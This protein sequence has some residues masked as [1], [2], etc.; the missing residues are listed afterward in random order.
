MRVEGKPELTKKL[1]ENF[2][3][4]LSDL[5]HVVNFAFNMKSHD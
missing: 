1:L 2:S 5:V 3:N 4:A